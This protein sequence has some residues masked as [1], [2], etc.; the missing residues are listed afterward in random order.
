MLRGASAGPSGTKPS[1]P[2]MSSPFLLALV[3]FAGQGAS[4]ARDPQIVGN[5]V[6]ASVRHKPADFPRLL[7]TERDLKEIEARG[8]TVVRKDDIALAVDEA[9][10]ASSPAYLQV[11][12]VAELSSRSGEPMRLGD[13]PEPVRATL[14]EAM[15]E[16]G[17]FDPDDN[18]VRVSLRVTAGCEIEND[19]KPF[20]FDFTDP[21]GS[22]RLKLL[23]ASLRP[24]LI[25]PLPK[26][27]D[28]RSVT[29][30]EPGRR[31]PDVLALYERLAPEWRKVLDKRL[32]AVT[33]PLTGVP[34]A[35][36]T[37]L[38]SSLDSLVPGQPRAFTSL[39]P[40]AQDLIR[41]SAPLGPNRELVG[42]EVTLRRAAIRIVLE[43]PGRGS[44][45]PLSFIGNP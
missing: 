43:K 22:E 14:K 33:G 17:S 42:S 29:I 40:A 8:Y 26:D 28:P 45:F 24:P 6:I 19:G 1:A 5:V 44:V 30:F 41:R 2:K 34:S 21:K 31:N 23:G 13:I 18:E 10:I 3:A 37:E 7:K 16:Y 25:P 15:S 12:I 39:S 38:Q 20:R 32:S 36:G 9:L 35:F 11:R 27:S 4:D